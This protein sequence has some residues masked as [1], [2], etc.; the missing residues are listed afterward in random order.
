[1]GSWS[2]VLSRRWPSSCALP[3][4]IVLLTLGMFCSPGISDAQ[5]SPRVPRLGVLGLDSTIAPQAQ[6]GFRAELRAL[7]YVDGQTI[8]IEYRWA[9]GRLDRLP[10][11]AAELVALPVNV[12]VT[13]Q[14]MLT[15]R[16]AQKATTTIPIVSMIMNDPVKAGVVTSLARPGGNLTGQAFQDAELSIKQLE[17]LREAVP[18]LTRVAVLW[19]AAG[20]GTPVVRAVEDAAQV[21]GL[22]LYIREV[23]ELLDLDRAVAAA[24]AW[25]AQAVLQLASPFFAQH[26]KTLVAHL[27]TH[28]L[29]AMCETRLLVVE[30]CLMAYGANFEAMMRRTAYYVDRI[31]KGAKPGDLPVEEPR[32]FVFVLNRQTSQALGLTLSPSLLVQVTEVLQ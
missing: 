22:R 7:G 17:L 9:E 29:P 21:L 26:G 6:A 31:L 2:P 12:L 1:M 4:L 24:K 10:A 14:G 19:H 13:T 32:E 15:V 27:T 30:G 18:R 11:L 20:S 3:G 25:G 28:H 16:A 23:R 8:I 5:R